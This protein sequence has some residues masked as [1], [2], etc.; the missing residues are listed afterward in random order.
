MDDRDLFEQAKIYLPKY[1]SAAK[2]EELW[3][4]LKSFPDNRSFY[5]AES[6]LPVSPLQSDGWTGLV[7]IDFYSQ[8]RKTVPAGL[9]LSNSCDISPENPRALPPNILFTPLIKLAEYGAQ[10]HNSGMLSARVESL[11]GQIR[12]QR[13]SSIFRLPPNGSVLDESIALL[14]D[15]H[16]HPLPDFLKSGGSRLFSLSNFGFYLF[17][18]KLSIHFTRVREGISR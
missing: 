16:G 12:K 4:E 1:L 7:V 17:L 6:N 5:S 8:E 10:L 2:L 14:D 13:V 11:F 3:A 9:I 18:F 15:I